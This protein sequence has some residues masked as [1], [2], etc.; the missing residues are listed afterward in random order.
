MITVY[1]IQQFADELTIQVESSKIS[2]WA[3]RKSLTSTCIVLNM[4]S[5]L[6]KQAQFLLDGKITATQ[7]NNRVEQLRLV[8]EPQLN[9]R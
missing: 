4:M 3:A 5:D 9:D 6:T 1:D 7:Y 2:D 8:F